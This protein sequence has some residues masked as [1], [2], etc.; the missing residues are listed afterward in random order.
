M[1]KIILKN[2]SVSFPIFSW[3]GRS[4]KHEIVS[5]AVGGM[6][7]SKHN[8][9]T[10]VDALSTINL[11]INNGER[12][13]LVGH[14]GSGKTT[15]LRAISKIYYPTGGEI[16]VYGKVHSLIDI[17]LG[18]DYEATGRENIYLRGL[19]MGLSKKEIESYED[20]IIAFS[21]L[22]EFIDLPIRMYSSGMAVRLAFSIA[23][24]VES[25][26]LIMDEWLSVGDAEFRAKAQA[27]LQEVIS[28]TKILVI[29][30]HDPVLV[31]QVCNRKIHLEHGKVISDERL[32]SA[33]VN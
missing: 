1:A 14:N 32:D 31:E 17:M 12:V 25:D 4:I 20:E 33:L 30:T 19:L 11:E 23:T 2:A 15:L 16:E 27:K 13:A 6:I 28:R 10:C 9:P 18:V 8:R 21:E 3:H 7:G 26:I 24:V 22:D 5:Y 29:A